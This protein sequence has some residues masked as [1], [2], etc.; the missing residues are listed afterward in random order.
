MYYDFFF[1]SNPWH[2]HLVQISL[3]TP[4]MMNTQY[5]SG[6]CSGIAEELHL[7]VL[8]SSIDWDA[9]HSEWGF[10]W[11]YSVPPGKFRASTMIRLCSFHP[12]ISPIHHTLHHHWCYADWDTDSVVKKP[13]KK[14]SKLHHFAGPLPKLT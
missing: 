14:A 5:Q 1:F 9:N 11:F 4:A 10:S 8:Q 3:N 7:R 2:L 12:E 13:W 6:W